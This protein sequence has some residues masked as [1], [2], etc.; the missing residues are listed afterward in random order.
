MNLHIPTL[1]FN[2]QLCEVEIKIN[3][4]VEIAS[5]FYEYL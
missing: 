2:N 3:R 4:L 1:V 5:F